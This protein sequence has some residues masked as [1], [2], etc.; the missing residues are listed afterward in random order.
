VPESDAD[1]EYRFC[2][3]LNKL[4]KSPE[5]GPRAN[6]GMGFTSIAVEVAELSP[7]LHTQCLI[8]PA[9]VP[10]CL[11]RPPRLCW[12]LDPRPCLCLIRPLC[13]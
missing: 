11:I 5:S 12:V 10:V 6:G 7:F 8:R 9:P 1:T 13:L 4:Y 3:Q 2:K